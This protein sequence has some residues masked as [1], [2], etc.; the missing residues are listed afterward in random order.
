MVDQISDNSLIEKILGGDPSPYNLLIE[1][2]KD[3]AFTLALRVLNN[4]EDA[5]EVAHDA[6]LKAFRSLSSFKMESKF[7]TWF[8]KIVVNMSI[9]RRRK[10]RLDTEEIEV[11]NTTHYSSFEDLGGMPKDDRKYFIDQ[12]LEQLSD[13][14]K[15]LITLFYFE[16]L[17]MEEVSEI[18]GIDRNNLKVKIFRARKKMAGVLTKMLKG[19]VHSLL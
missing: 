12:A 3:Y 18:T 13:E 17:S 15:I 2:H 19:E 16:E 9:S 10:K 14:E 1:R 4:R 11:G 8:Y 7:T 5:E 6:F